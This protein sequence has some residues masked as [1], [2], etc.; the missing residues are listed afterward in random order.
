M[1]KPLIG[2]TA[3]RR[4]MPETGWVYDATYGRNAAAVLE[5]G[6]L[7]VLIPTILEEE[8][9]RQVYERVDGVLLPG[10]EDINPE[11]YKEDRHPKLGVVSD[12]RDKMELSIARWAVH[13]DRPLFGI[14]RGIQ[15]MNVALGGS[16]HQDIPSDFRTELRHDIFKEQNEPRDLLLHDVSVVDNSR[17]ATILG[18]TRVQVNS[19]HHQ[20]L[21]TIAPGLEITARADDG[22][23]EGI[24]MPDKRFVMAVQWHP[25]DL[26]DDDRMR[27][28]FRAFVDAARDRMND[29]SGAI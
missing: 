28:M 13:D 20:A 23:I 10:G 12:T 29:S 21:K 7:P 25:E 22:V 24:E 16:L 27:Q 15:V 18:A 3:Y 19:L 14:C 17:L 6:G 4:T 9:L 8:D 1:T 5:A 2:I 11:N 26:V